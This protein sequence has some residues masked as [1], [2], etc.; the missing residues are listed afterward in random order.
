MTTPIVI[1]DLDGT[2]TDSAPLIMESI[3]YA[4]QKVGKPQET[5]ENLPRW[6]GP[7]LAVSFRDFANIPAE[8]IA[9]AIAAYRENYGKFMYDV[10]IFPGIIAMLD[11]LKSAGVPLG[12]ATSKV[13]RLAVP[14]VEKVG[15]SS[16]FQYVCGAKDDGAHHTK[17]DLIRE[18]MDFF[19]TE[20]HSLDRVFM[21][22]D[23]IYDIE[24][25]QANA[26]NTIGVGWAGTDEAEFTQATFIAKTPADL[27]DFVLNRS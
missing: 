11:L 25:G 12:I 24:G 3:N 23:R 8:G 16:Y 4:L 15:L 18:V 1:F 7:P 6:V 22:G 26:I 27:A 14:I 10:P 9:E 20:G 13:E 21:V 5:A 19:A 17:A 2:L